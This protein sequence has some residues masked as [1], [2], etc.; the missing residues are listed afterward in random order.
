MSIVQIRKTQ[1]NRFSFPN[2]FCSVSHISLRYNGAKLINYLV[3]TSLGKVDY[4][5]RIYRET[6]KHMQHVKVKD[7]F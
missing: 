4:S 6:I 1:L 3:E 2:G 7:R 5:L